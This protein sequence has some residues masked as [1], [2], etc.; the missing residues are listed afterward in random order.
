M[1]LILSLGVRRCLLSS[2]SPNPF[3]LWASLGPSRGA[4]HCRSGKV[5]G[6]RTRRARRHCPISSRPRTPTPQISP[7]REPL[8]ASIGPG[9]PRQGG[10]P[11]LTGWIIRQTCPH[12]TTSPD[13]FALRQV[14]N[15]LSRGS[16]ASSATSLGLQ[17]R[18]SKLPCRAE[19]CH[20][21]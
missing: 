16:C 6:S 15:R 1:V 8:A 5:K 19:A 7:H 14:R 18:A 10:E 4:H 20:S 17:F 13:P 21:F 12:A 3:R 9:A 2:P 11:G